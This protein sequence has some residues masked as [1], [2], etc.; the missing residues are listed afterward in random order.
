[1]AGAGIGTLALGA[2]L[3]IAMKFAVKKIRADGGTS[4][5]SMNRLSKSELQDHK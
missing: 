3:G 1:M 4:N 2:A 5:F